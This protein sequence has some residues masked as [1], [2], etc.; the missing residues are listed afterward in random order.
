MTDQTGS[1]AGC[2]SVRAG[3]LWFVSLWLLGVLTV[4]AVAGAG[5][6]LM[7]GATTG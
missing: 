2:G 4:L 6:L 5:K 1:T 7:W 3:L